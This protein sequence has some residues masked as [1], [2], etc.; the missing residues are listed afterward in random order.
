MKFA[1]KNCSLF[2]MLF[3]ISRIIYADHSFKNEI[4]KNELLLEGNLSVI[5]YHGKKYLVSVGIAEIEKKGKKG[6][7]MARK[8]ASI[9]AEKKINEYLNDIQLKSIT[10]LKMSENNSEN[11]E[12]YNEEFIERINQKSEGILKNILDLDRWKTDDDEYIVVKGFKFPE[13]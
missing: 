13:D 4:Y 12:I 6:K 11:I 1:I 2:V 5:K 3:F 8:K 7:I 10:T 9:Y